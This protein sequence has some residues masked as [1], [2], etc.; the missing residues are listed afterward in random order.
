MAAVAKVLA[1]CGATAAGGATCV[2]TGV[3]NPEAI[4]GGGGTEKPALERPVEPTRTATVPQEEPTDGPPAG[5][6]AE[7]AKEASGATQ[8]PTP[9]QQKTHQFGVESP[10]PSSSTS[11]SSSG[12]FGGASGGGGSGGGGSS[13]GSSG[14]G[15]E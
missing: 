9:V 7:P 2:T 3:F 6:V 13:G 14:F 4:T 8:Q 12:E 11:S 5:Q 10:P 15:I 1:I